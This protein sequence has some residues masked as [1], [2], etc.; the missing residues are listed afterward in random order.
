MH[1]TY[2]D[3]RGSCHRDS[4]HCDQ[5]W[6][7]TGRSYP[8]HKRRSWAPRPV[9]GGALPPTATS[10]AI[11]GLSGV[12]TAPG[13]CITASQARCPK[14]DVCSP[15]G[16]SHRTEVRGAT[17]RAKNHL[18]RRLGAPGGQWTGISANPIEFDCGMDPCG[19]TCPPQPTVWNLRC[20]RDPRRSSS[21]HPSSLDCVAGELSSLGSSADLLGA[22]S[23][24]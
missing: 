15:M 13:V 16:P 3:Q 10:S 7:W 9:A 21:G 5:S 4:R 12:P 20:R 2:I 11:A 19:A 22:G 24:C 14:R 6:S 23:R 18:H 1:R 17:R 8:A